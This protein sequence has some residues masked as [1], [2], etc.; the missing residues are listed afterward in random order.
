LLLDSR[1]RILLFS[2]RVVK[3]QKKSCSHHLFRRGMVIG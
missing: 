3:S 2:I 1:S